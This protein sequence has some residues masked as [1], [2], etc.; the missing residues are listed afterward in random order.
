M[1][2]NDL[3]FNLKKGD[4]AAFR[5]LFSEYYTGLCIYAQKYTRDKLSA[6]EVVHNTIVKLWENRDR[7]EISTTVAGYLFMAVK[8]NALNFL[9]QLYSRSNNN[10]L[11]SQYLHD[12]QEYF[13]V[14]QETG[15]SII[16]AKELE[17]QIFAAI[18]EL[19]DQCREIFKL[20]RM[21]GLKNQEIANKKNITI[22]TVQ[23]QISIA[24][25]KLRLSLKQYLIISLTL[26]LL[27]FIAD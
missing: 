10:Q 2:E 9:K 18:E 20:S 6:E 27:F 26:F 19:P 21:T 25:D 14:S 1:H 7:L 17:S 12:A 8:N 5:F 22:N 24:L 15:Q 16:L 11:Y 4:P 13:T 3:R 23:K